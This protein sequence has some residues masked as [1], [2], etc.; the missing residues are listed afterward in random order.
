[1]LFPRSYIVRQP[2]GFFGRRSPKLN[3]GKNFLCIILEPMDFTRRDDRNR[4]GTQAMTAFI[5]MPVAVAVQH[6]TEMMTIGVIMSRGGIT[7]VIDDGLPNDFAP[8]LTLSS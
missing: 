7:G 2:D 5:H 1:V 8:N 6:I 4:P 3:E